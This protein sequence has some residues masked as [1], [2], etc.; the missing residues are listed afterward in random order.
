LIEPQVVVPDASVILK[1][2]LPPV[3]ES[4]VEQAIRLRDAIA[5]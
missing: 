4:D 1:W 3:D 5:N 2:V